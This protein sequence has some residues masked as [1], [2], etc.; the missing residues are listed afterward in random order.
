MSHAT[1]TPDP[2][3]PKRLATGGVVTMSHEPS[4]YPPTIPCACKTGWVYRRAIDFTTDRQFWVRAPCPMCSGSGHAGPP[5]WPDEPPIEAW[6]EVPEG[7][8]VP[9]RTAHDL[10]TPDAEAD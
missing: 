1:N 8:P 7:E 9:P 3:E 5:P 10:Y 6:H 2:K 4:T